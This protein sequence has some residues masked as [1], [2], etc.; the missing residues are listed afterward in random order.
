MHPLAQKFFDMEPLQKRAVHLYLARIALERWQDYCQS[1]VP[2]AYVETVAGTMQ[3]VEVDLPDDALASATEGKD[4]NSVAE[5]YREPICALQDEDWPLSDDMQ[6]AYYTI[7]NVFQKYA[8]AKEIDD[9]LIVN[10]AL[11]SLG[12]TSESTIITLSEAVNSVA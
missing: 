12:V 3:E 5:R 2:M 4:I 6:F 10:Q 9:W 7:Y 1:G 11:S 8:L